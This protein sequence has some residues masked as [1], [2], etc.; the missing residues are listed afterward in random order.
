MPQFVIPDSAKPVAQY[1]ASLAPEKRSEISDA[2]LSIP[3]NSD[4]SDIAI[5]LAGILKLDP[6]SSFG[7]VQF[8]IGLFQSTLTYGVDKTLSDFRETIESEYPG[9]WEI[10][11][12]ELKRVLES[13]SIE[14]AFLFARGE[15]FQSA[16]DH[17]FLT[18][19]IV[20]SLVPFQVSESQLSAV[21][22]H[23][24][25]ITY[26]HGPRQDFFVIT[27]SEKD[28]QFLKLILNQTEAFSNTITNLVKKG[29]LDMLTHSEK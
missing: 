5:H 13:K 25:K 29:N 11:F 21:L 20:T 6:D 10:F 9:D 23:E 3:Q 18:A 22:S 7:L 8:Y 27:L 17:A 24:L 2:L 4:S 16:A 28:I 19:G 1:L 14:T 26:S 15:S 12:E